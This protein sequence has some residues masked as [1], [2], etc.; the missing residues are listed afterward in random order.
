MELIE[1]AWSDGKGLEKR[2]YHQQKCSLVADL[3]AAKCHDG[4]P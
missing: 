1:Q 3:V 4:R 2:E